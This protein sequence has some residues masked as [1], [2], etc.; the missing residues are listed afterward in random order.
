[1]AD[2]KIDKLK[3]IKFA[4]IRYFFSKNIKILYKANR[5]LERPLF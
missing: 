3:K 5:A 1:M 2:R 4:R